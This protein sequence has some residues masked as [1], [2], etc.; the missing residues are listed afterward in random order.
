M[1]GGEIQQREVV[2]LEYG[3]PAR[4]RSLDIHAIGAGPLSRRD[5]CSHLR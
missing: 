5:P 2:E 1:L 4:I 3:I